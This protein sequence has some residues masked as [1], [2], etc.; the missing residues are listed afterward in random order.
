MASWRWVL[1]GLDDGHELFGLPLQLGL[2]VSQR[3][4]Q[5]FLYG[6]QGRDMSGGRYYIVGR[7]AEI[8]VVVGVHRR[9]RPDHAAQ[10]FYCTV[11]D[12]LVGVHVRGCP[13]A[14][15]ENV[16]DK[17]VVELAVRHFPGG[18]GYDIGQFR[19][20]QPQLEIGLRRRHLNVAEGPD[21]RAGEPQ[22]ADREVHHG[23]HGLGPVVGVG[24]HLEL[25]H[26]V[27]LCAVL[28]RGSFHFRHPPRV[29]ITKAV[30]FSATSS[31]CVSS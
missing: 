13:G 28:F 23:S 24:G 3:R 26:R 31:S 27:P 30:A 8:H 12:D 19:A 2:E 20:E 5:V 29:S 1:A 25:S 17:L 7:L 22:V 16:H 21:E 18:L 11:G 4:D 9:A 14:C 6:L 10:H 15:L